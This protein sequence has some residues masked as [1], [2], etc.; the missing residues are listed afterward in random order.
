MMKRYAPELRHLMKEYI[1]IHMEMVEL[2]EKIKD[3][4]ND[5]DEI[6]SKLDYIRLK[7]SNLINRIEEE[8]GRKPTQEELQDLISE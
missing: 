5:R 2:D 4:S 6:Q 7:E 8:I 1:E 3:L